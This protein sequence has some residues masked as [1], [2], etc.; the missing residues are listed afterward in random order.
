[1]GFIFCAHGT[2]YIFSA[3][4]PSYSSVL[5]AASTMDRHARQPRNTN[6]EISTEVQLLGKFLSTSTAR[7]IGVRS[8]GPT[9]NTLHVGP[10]TPRA[11]NGRPS[12]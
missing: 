6:H 9:A 1:M 11:V 3:F 7:R 8:Y 4:R 5:V 2:S 10:T 12:E